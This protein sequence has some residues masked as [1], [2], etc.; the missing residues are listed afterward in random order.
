MNIDMTL[1]SFF[2][3]TEVPSFYI[4]KSDNDK[5]LKWL[6]SDD[7]QGIKN[8]LKKI[9]ELIEYLSEKSQ[10]ISIKIIET[11]SILEYA[12]RIINTEL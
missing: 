8:D 12:L 2:R 5:C 10:P 11:K 6:I 1:E 7:E 9:N 4:S 3:K